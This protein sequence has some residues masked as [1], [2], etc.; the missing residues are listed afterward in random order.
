MAKQ[1]EI[2]SVAINLQIK[3]NALEKGLETAKKKLQ[4]IEEENKKVQ[5]SNKGLESTYIAMSAVAV[6]S[7]LKI[8]G[9]IKDCINEYKEY[10]Q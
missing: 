5:N 6:A 8:G 3:L 2:G 9:A 7:L 4:S 10:T 1:T